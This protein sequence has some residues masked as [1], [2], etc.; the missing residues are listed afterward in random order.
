MEILS[1]RKFLKSRRT[2]DGY[3]EAHVETAEGEP[4]AINFGPEISEQLLWGILSLSGQVY[5]SDWKI[6]PLQPDHIVR[7]KLSDGSIEL[8]FAFQN[9]AAVAV[10]LTSAMQQTLIQALA[11]S[12]PGQTTDQND[13]R[14]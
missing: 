12:S 8:R 13:L 2:K 3:L 14:H 5:A 4:V 10:R 6:W 7:S 11:Q 9:R 1:I